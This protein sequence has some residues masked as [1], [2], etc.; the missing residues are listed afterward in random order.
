[1][2]DFLLQSHKKK[3]PASKRKNH[4]KVEPFGADGSVD[5]DNSDEEPQPQV[6][7]AKKKGKRAQ[8]EKSD[9]A[10]DIADNM[11]DDYSDDASVE[12]WV[13]SMRTPPARTSEPKRRKVS[14]DSEVINISSD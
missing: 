3:A 1:M 2:Y 13:S 5:S 12:L 9:S 7:S 4:G 11:S 14:R 6:K 10:G 8:P